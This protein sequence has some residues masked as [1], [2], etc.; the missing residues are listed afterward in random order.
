[1]MFAD[2]VQESSANAHVSLKFYKRYRLMKSCPCQ[3]GSDIQEAESL[4]IVKLV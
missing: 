3:P 1:M 4:L 2:R